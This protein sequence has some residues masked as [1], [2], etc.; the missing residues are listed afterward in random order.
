MSFIMQTRST[1]TFVVGVDNL[2]SDGDDD[3]HGGDTANVNGGG[4]G[5]GVPTIVA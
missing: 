1:A 2:L 5:V 4:V 3:Q